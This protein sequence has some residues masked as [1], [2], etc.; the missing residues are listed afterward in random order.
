MP[1]V[2]QR[3]CKVLIKI[4]NINAAKNFFW[5]IDSKNYPEYYASIRKP[6]VS[7]LLLLLLFRRHC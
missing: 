6:R 3:C 2:Y 5:E 4:C 7:M 1:E